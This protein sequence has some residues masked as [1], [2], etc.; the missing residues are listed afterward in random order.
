[1]HNFLLVQFIETIS[2]LRFKYIGSYPPDD[3]PQLTKY[4]FAIIYSTPGIERG[5][6]R[7]MSPRWD[8]TYHFADSLSKNALTPYF[9][10]NYRQMISQIM[11]ISQPFS[12]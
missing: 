1:M 7:I 9:L 5:K 4:P 8:K 2:E 3:A 10:E 6:H 11:Q 12:F